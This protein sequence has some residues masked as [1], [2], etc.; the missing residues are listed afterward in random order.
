MGEAFPWKQHILHCLESTQYMSLS[1]ADSEL[2]T[3]VNPVY[4]A[5]DKAFNLYFV[6]MPHSRH[7]TNMRTDPRVSIAIYSTAQDTLGDVEGIQ[8]HGKAEF[9]TEEHEVELAYNIYYARVYPETRKGI[10]SVAADYRG[11]SAEWVFV[12]IIPE[13]IFYFNT[14]FFGH[15]RQLVPVDQ[16]SV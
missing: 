11:D 2:G 10:D 4:F 1:T 12:K 15:E 13:E 6:S 3:W 16:L 7:M 9:V 14:E 8:L 5:W